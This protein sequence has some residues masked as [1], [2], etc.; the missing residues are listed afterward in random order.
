MN[1]RFEILVAAL[2]L[3]V[4]ASSNFVLAQERDRNRKPDTTQKAMVPGNEPASKEDKDKEA[5][6]EGD[7]VFRGMKYRSIGPF[8]GGRAL[9]AA[10]IPGD[11]TTY[12]FGAT[13]GGVWKSTDGANSWTPVFD[14]DGSPAIGSL[15]VAGSD[16][17]VIYVGTGEGC[18]R[19]NIAQGDG[20]WKSVDA[21]KTWKNAGL[22]D[23]RAIGKVIVNPQNANIAF[24]AVLGHPYGPNAERGIFRTVDGGKTWE[25]VLYKDEN[26][27]AIDVA[28]D[29]RN[30]NILF[31]A[32]WEVRRTP[33]SL[34]SGG[35]GSGIY[36]SND[37]G[38]TW[39]HLE[40]HGLPKGPYG[41]V[42][43]AVAANSERVYALI[44][45]KEKGGLYRSDDGG[46]SWDLVNGNHGLYQRA[47]YYMHVI[48]D[49]SDANT[50]YVADVEFFKSTDGGRTF[51]KVK[52]PHGDNHGLWID[53]K[54]SK[55]M[56]ASDDGGATVSMDGGKSWTR[57]DNQPTAQFYHVITDSRTPY[58]VYGSQQ[59][60][61]SVAIASRSDG[62]AIGRDNW[63]PVGGG[64]SGYIAPS[65]A[66]PNIV[67]AGGYQGEI[68]RFDR[69]TNQV[70]EIAVSPE[71]SDA[72]GAASLE[73]R[74]QWTA[75]IVIS[76]QDANT[77]YYGGERIFKTT[78]GGMHWEAISPDLTRNDKSK[79][80]ASGGPVTIDD[81]GTEY[82]DTVFS[83]APSPVAKGLIWAGTD[84]GLIQLTRDE[85]KNWTNVTPKDVPEWSRVSLIEASPFEAG[86]AYVAIDRH[87]NDDLGVYIYKTGD[88]GA[89]WTRVGSGIPEGAF[90][91]AVR[92]DPKR[93]GLLYAGT[94]RGVY[95][96]FDDGGHW[97]SLQLNLPNVPVHDLVVKND[98]LVVATHGR[99]FWILDD[100]SPLRQYVDSVA[101]EEMHLYKP[102]T[103]FRTHAGENSRHHAFAGANPPNGALIYYYFKKAPKEE[104]KIEILDSAGSV[105]R[106]YSSK[107]TEPLDEPRA[108]E[109]KKPEKQI[110][111]EDGLNRF[112][113]DL[114][115]ED[116]RR[117]PG[118]YLWE[119][120]DGARGPLAVPGNYQVRLTENG[121]SQTVPLELKIDPR[122]TVSQADLQKQFKLEMDLQEQLNRVYD[123]VNQIEDVREQLDGMK[124]RVGPGDTSKALMDGV[125]ALDVKLIEVRDPL[126]NFKISASEDS[127]AYIPGIDGK[128]AFLSMSV[129]GDADSAPTAAED[130][131]FDKLKKQT[132]TLLARWEQV[133]SVDL[134][135]FQKLAAEQHVPPIYVPDARSERVLG[136]GSGEEERRE[137]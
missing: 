75:P 49:P 73:H 129:A 40:E 105:I 29:P 124:K 130:Q 137:P 23:S 86:A 123:A 51:N 12:Y 60:N 48:A 33:W 16:P 97:R 70:Q 20:V 19:G 108:P 57:E 121:K 132:D 76:P 126:I 43:V 109:D 8:R 2:A 56:I 104:V 27:G 77:V 81:T 131:E 41:R 71:L 21:G 122:V 44:E 102:A 91:R 42:G 134:G 136:G 88:Y 67:Y 55:R 52:P 135:N 94:E 69:S 115:Y 92:E 72:A 17:N 10:G 14:H 99:A 84:D 82:Y 118:Y 95:V 32:L 58:Y 38:A 98:D 30:P 114:H 62:G 107:A 90:V 93:K 120:G 25:K 54:D 87:Q 127:L 22:E 6:S 28:F 79:Q 13:G 7:P 4:V 59:D 18:I 65:P 63:Y 85:G 116:A 15:A 112:V 46:D 50:V 125:K 45:S 128:L 31:A 78:D 47:W 113:W 89:T 74:F 68:T 24:V 39:K 3:L 117:V 133:R 37:G 26:T 96:S 1:R 119:Y 100:V 9:T 64:E 61:S 101:A 110:K 35:P 66:D 111:L 53:P 11:A 80:Q 36:R 34:S 5:K 103:A 83:I 106:S